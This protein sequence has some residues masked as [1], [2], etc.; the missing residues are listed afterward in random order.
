MGWCDR[1]RGTGARE[2]MCGPSFGTGIGVDY[3]AGWVWPCG[4]AMVI[5]F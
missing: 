1:G 4:L 5:M 3:G 2:C